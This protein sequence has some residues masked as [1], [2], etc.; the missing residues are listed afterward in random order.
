MIKVHMDYPDPHVTIHHN[1]NCPQAR[2]EKSRQQRHVLLNVDTLSKELARFGA[3]GYRFAAEP[4]LSDLWLVLDF[5][6][7]EFEKAL[8]SHLKRLVGRQY[9]PLGSCELQVHC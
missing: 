3:N 1:P 9:G 5:L 8:A 7:P 2:V 4:G 6:D